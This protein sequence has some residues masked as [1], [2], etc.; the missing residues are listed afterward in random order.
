V[1]GLSKWWLG[2]QHAPH[3]CREALWPWPHRPS[4]PP[5]A[6]PSTACLNQRTTPVRH[7]K[8]Q[9]QAKLELHFWFGFEIMEN[10]NDFATFWL[11]FVS[12]TIRKG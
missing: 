1:I 2:V 8:F 11:K 5:H 6:A 3:H 9:T 10:Q 12:N 4:L 7:Q